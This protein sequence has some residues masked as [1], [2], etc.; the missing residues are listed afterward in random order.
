VSDKLSS[1]PPRV[2]QMLV[3]AFSPSSAEGE[4][5]TAMREVDRYLASIGSDGYEVIARIKT[6]PLDEDAMREQLK[7][8][9]RKIFDVGYAKRVADEAEQRQRA[10]AVTTPPANGDV[11]EGFG[12]YSWREIV[13]HCV[14]NRH[15]IRNTWEANFVASVA[16]RPAFI[17]LGKPTENQAPILRRIFQ[18]WFNGKI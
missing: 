17:R 14:A 12:G 18:S 7:S 10:I 9:A 6:P 5:V 2:V 4:R 11:G 15:V 8:E 13:G 16:E 3:V 1:M